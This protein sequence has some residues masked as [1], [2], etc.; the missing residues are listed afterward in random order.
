[1]ISLLTY[2]Q[3]DPGW[4]LLCPLLTLLTIS[5]SL[6]LELALVDLYT[7]LTTGITLATTYLYRAYHSDLLAVRQL[8][9]WKDLKV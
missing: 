7:V 8:K 3:S 4:L 6:L 1:M 2:C 5:L 9:R